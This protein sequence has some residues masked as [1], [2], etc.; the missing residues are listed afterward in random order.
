[1]VMNG[2]KSALS[3]LEK[4]Q[5][6]MEQRHI[7]EKDEAVKAV[8]QSK[9]EVIKRQ[10]NQLQSGANSLYGADLA[11]KAYK[12]PTRLDI[13]VNNRVT[14]AFGVLGKPP[15]FEAMKVENERLIKDMDEIKTSLA[16]L[17]AEHNRILKEKEQI[18]KE[19][20][21]AVIKE[22]QATDNLANVETKHSEE[23]NELNS[24]IKQKQKE[25][26]DEQEKAI[27]R[28]KDLKAVKT[29]IST[30][31]GIIAVLCLA[32]AIYSPVFKGKFAMMSGILG[33]C[34]IGV[35]FIEPWMVAVGFGII[36]VCV[37]GFFAWE[38]HIS[39]SANEN[40]INAIQD[41]KEKGNGEVL[42]AHLK[43]WNTK[44]V[45]KDGSYVE[46]ADKRI[47]DYID[48]K[49]MEY[50]RLKTDKKP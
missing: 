36:F 19:K 44:Y 43:E 35:W 14:E 22:K 20:D 27:E 48:K 45:K 7:K 39:D 23:S 5:T 32:G 34:A 38:H 18:A 30:V 10:E 47:E 16:S 12:Q 21:A 24:K 1:M 37:L 49:L 33:L 4:K 42:K 25:L 15:T 13:I 26:I 28:E 6:E 3:D 9:D 17:Q 11:F 29:K 31:C 8:V 46:V 50:G 40:M 2:T 41:N